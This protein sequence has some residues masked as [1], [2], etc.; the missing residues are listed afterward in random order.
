MNLVYI[1][2]QT[3]L[4]LSDIGVLTHNAAAGLKPEQKLLIL[5]QLFV[6][7]PIIRRVL[8]PSVCNTAGDSPADL[9]QFLKYSITF[10][11]GKNAIYPILVKWCHLT[12]PCGFMGYWDLI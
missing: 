4:S 2:K 12:G 6:F 10:S 3:P 11:K 5:T 1:K 7:V 9:H 8:R